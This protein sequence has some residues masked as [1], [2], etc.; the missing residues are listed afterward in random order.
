MSTAT[1]SPLQSNTVE[2]QCVDGPVARG[3]SI[4]R[5]FAA[6]RSGWLSWGTSGSAAVGTRHMLARVVPEYLPLRAA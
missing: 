2:P 3:R 6:R 1:A 5:S 4:R